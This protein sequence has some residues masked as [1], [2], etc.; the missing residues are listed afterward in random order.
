MSNALIVVPISMVIG[1]LFAFVSGK[2]A[3]A[4]TK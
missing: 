1:A 4:L 3:A 2:G